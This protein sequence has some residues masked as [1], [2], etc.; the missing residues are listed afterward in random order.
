MGLGGA[1]WIGAH[2]TATGTFLVTLLCNATPTQ[3]PKAVCYWSAV[4]NRS[5]RGK[6]PTE[7]LTG[8]AH[9]HWLEL[10]GYKRFARPA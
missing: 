8:L 3:H 4:S 2:R 6:T 9:G 10:L 1:S 5:A 7:L